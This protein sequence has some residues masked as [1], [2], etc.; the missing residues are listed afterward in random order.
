MLFQLRALPRAQLE[1]L[2]NR[3]IFQ[4]PGVLQ[5]ATQRGPRFVLIL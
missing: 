1:L 4:P 5:T 2:R 3:G